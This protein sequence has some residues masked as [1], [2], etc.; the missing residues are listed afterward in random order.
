MASPCL[1][2]GNNMAV[3]H[4]W[5][6]KLNPAVFVILGHIL[7]R[8]KKTHVK[9]ENGYT[10]RASDRV[11]KICLINGLLLECCQSLQIWHGH[12]GKSCSQDYE[13]AHSVSS[14]FM[15]KV[16]PL[17]ILVLFMDKGPCLHKGTTGRR[18]YT[19]NLYSNL[20]ANLPLFIAWPGI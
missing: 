16:L 14:H 15:S 9:K 10:G 17:A 11:S 19:W 20:Y 3:E 13:K 6:S 1:G 12:Q 8:K 5:I 7:I 2:R 18:W 4:T